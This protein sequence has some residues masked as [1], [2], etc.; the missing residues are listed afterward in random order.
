MRPILVSLQ[1]TTD[2]VTVNIGSREIKV[3]FRDTITLTALGLVVA[4]VAPAVADVVSL[5]SNESP[6]REKEKG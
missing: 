5:S 6:E 3:I 4:L 2:I 1:R